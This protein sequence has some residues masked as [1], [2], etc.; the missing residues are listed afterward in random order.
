MVLERQR[1]RP[2]EVLYDFMALYGELRQVLVNSVPTRCICAAIWGRTVRQRVLRRGC[3]RWE[4]RASV[5]IAPHCQRCLLHP[6][7]SPD[8]RAVWTI[9]FGSIYLEAETIQDR[10][11]STVLMDL[12]DQMGVDP[13]VSP[14]LAS[15]S[16]VR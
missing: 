1:H 10:L 14:T 13:H 5:L 15:A 4:A 11:P 16:E 9:R 12:P 6:F 2:T 7:L 8:G 3:K